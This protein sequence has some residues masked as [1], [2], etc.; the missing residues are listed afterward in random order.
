MHLTQEIE[1]Q[2]V[3]EAKAA[4]CMLAYELTGAQ[5][6]L[7]VVSKPRDWWLVLTVI[8]HYIVVT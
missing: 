5:T 8:L 3:L 1:A 4:L 6:L 7:D 2:N